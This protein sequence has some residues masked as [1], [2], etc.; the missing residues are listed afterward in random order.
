MTHRRRYGDAGQAF[1]IYI[2][3]VAGLLFL[4]LVYFAVGQATVNRSGAQ[5]AADA[6]A[7]AAAQDTRDQLAGEWVAAV[8]DPNEWQDILT[9]HGRE[10]R[11]SC[12][13]AAE[14]AAQNDAHLLDGACRQ[15]LLGYTVRVETNNPMGESVV[16]LTST[17]HSK[18][19]AT[20]VIEPRCDI[21]PPA[22]DAGSDPLPVLTCHGKQWDL[23]PKNPADLPEP[24]D[25]FDVHLA[26]RP[27]NDE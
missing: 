16:P 8:L 11:S 17:K 4:A 15:R 22:A 12:W 14:L 24:Q 23:D 3:V 2:T 26:D 6:A 21:G 19:S 13:R 20:A 27:A 9:G 18:A 10:V 5:T 7:L 1:P 25:L